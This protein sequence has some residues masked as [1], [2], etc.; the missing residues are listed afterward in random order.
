MYKG[1]I[2]GIHSLLHSFDFW[3]LAHTKAACNRIAMEVAI[4]VNRDGRHQSYIAREG[5]LWLRHLINLDAS[6]S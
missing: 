2:D 1:L 5:P 6:E 4:S 3:S